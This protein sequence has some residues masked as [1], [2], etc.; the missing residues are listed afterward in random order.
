MN[1]AHTASSLEIYLTSNLNEDSTNESWGI[2]NFIIEYLTEDACEDVKINA[3]NEELLS[4]GNVC[5]LFNDFD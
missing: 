3:C 4:A 1:V 5:P 2:S